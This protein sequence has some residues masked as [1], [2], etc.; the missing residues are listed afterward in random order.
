M[1]TLSPNAK[2]FVP[3]DIS[4]QATSDVPV[5]PVTPVFYN[6]TATDLVIYHGKCPDG[7]AG[8]WPL[9][10]LLSR[11]ST[12]FH[13]G[14]FGESP[15]D[16]TNKNV[17]FV[18]FSYPLEVIQGMLAVAKSV[19]VL[20]HHKTALPL[21]SIAHPNFTSVIDMDR[22][23][24]QIAWDEVYGKDSSYNRPRPWFVD[25]IADRDLWQWK[26]DRS[27]DSCL[28]M[29]SLGYYES[30]EEFDKVQYVPKDY[31]LNAGYILNFKNKQTVDALVSRAIDCIATSLTDP[32]KTWKVRVVE[33]DH[34]M[35]SDVGNKLVLDGLCD[36][37]IM[38]RYDI[39]KDEWWCS[40]RADNK[41]TIDLTEVLKHFDPKSGGHPKAAGFSLSGGKN[42]RSI[43]SVAPEKF[44]K[45]QKSADT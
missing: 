24:A 20:D 40:A 28:A 43:L 22:S 21:C 7:T 35:A 36:F 32:T 17:V 19:R 33:C 45:K 16:V 5:N 23:G 6:Y 18:D 44:A 8:A 4:T 31:L 34:T 14:K 15:P 37:S 1:S 10:T 29:F 2:T 9:W 30:I 27:V 42:L 25:A 13:P 39:V 41:N 11:D 12:K 3:M 26:V 38:Y